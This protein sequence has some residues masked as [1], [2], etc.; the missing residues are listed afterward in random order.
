M[1]PFY[2]SGTTHPHISFLAVI[3]VINHV[4][5]SLFHINVLISV[6]KM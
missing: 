6:Q 5:T 4:N 2:A 1:L 3:A